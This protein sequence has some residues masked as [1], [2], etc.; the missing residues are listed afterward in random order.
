MFLAIRD[1][2][3][4]RGRFGLMAA[5]VALLTFLVVVLSG[6][7]AGLAAQSTSAVAELPADHLA[8][9]RPADGR[10]LSFDS[11]T[12]TT[13][14]ERTWAGAPGVTDAALLG[15]APNRLASGSTQLPVTLLGALPGSFV[16]PAALRSDRVVVLGPQLLET[17][18]VA[19]GQTVVVGGHE[20]RVAAGQQDT[21]FNHV[22]AAWVALATWDQLQGRT[23]EG[24][25][26]HGTVVALRTA[27]GAD[28]SAGDAAAG[29]T[30]VSRTGAFAAIGSYSAE[31]G[32]LSLIRGLLFG[33]GALVVGAFFTV[34]TIQRT[35]D[36]AVLKAMGATTGYLVRDS[37]AQAGVVLA[38][39]SIVGALA[40]TGVGLL[41]GATV[42]FLVSPATTV[43]PLS[44]TFGVG[45]LGALVAVRSIATV[46]P[47]TALGAAR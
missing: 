41:A 44:V 13:A 42:P 14:Q 8:F 40:A 27:T 24:T 37:L 21:S 28:L 20:L 16:A 45:L 19:P 38:V 7:A 9:Q 15:V 22:P 31:N 34:W 12:V 33:V 43:V 11:S 18:G 39:G 32:S 26:P 4:A 29:T 25:G 6:L 35:P 3:F 30:T 36:L 47:I 17:A 5:V 10:T 23:G 46:D 2:R 1:L